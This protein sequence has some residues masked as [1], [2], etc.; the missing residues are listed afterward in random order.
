MYI[1]KKSYKLLPISGRRV[2]LSVH[3][4]TV[5][6]N[7]TLDYMYYKYF[8]ELYSCY[9][10]LPGWSEYSATVIH[11]V[12]RYPIQFKWNA[13]TVYYIGTEYSFINGRDKVL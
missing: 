13:H 8:F 4:I 10:A 7:N 9:T 11:L 1:E 2:H 5:N 3:L 6:L 12:W